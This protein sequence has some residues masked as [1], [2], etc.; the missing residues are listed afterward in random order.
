MQQD[1]KK[2][3]YMLKYRNNFFFLFVCF[4]IICSLPKCENVCNSGTPWNSK[5]L[6]KKRW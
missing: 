6:D 4:I 1:F 3:E 2:S 5:S